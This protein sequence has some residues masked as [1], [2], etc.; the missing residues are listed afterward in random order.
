MHSGSFL[1]IDGH[2]G[3]VPYQEQLVQKLINAFV[4]KALQFLLLYLIVSES[5]FVLQV[6]CSVYF[7]S[8]L[9]SSEF[10]SQP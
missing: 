1:L 10:E 4:V 3:L 5:G 9:S 8:N 6:C 7:R 2:S